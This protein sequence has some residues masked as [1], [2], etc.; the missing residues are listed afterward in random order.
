MAEQTNRKMIRDKLVEILTAGV[1]DFGGSVDPTAGRVFENRMKPIWEAELPAANIYGINESAEIFNVAPR[2]Y[3]R[4]LNVRI[5]V[6]VTADANTDDSIDALTRKIEKVLFQNETL[7]GIVSDVVL[8][9]TE[10]ELDTDGRSLTGLA[11]MTWI[12]TY[13]T[14]APGDEALEG[15]D[16]F[17]TVNMK[18][19]PSEATANTPKIEDQFELEQED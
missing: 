16:D 9:D 1:A 11:R 10:M 3:K 15:L 8:G 6:V 14:F 19:A 12:V 18:M 2:E 4:T 5:D 13:F 17:E 7:D